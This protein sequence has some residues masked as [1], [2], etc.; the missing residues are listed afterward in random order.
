[1][2]W[3]DGSPLTAHDFEFA[4]KRNLDPTLAAPLASFLYPLTGAEDFFLGT[5]TDPSTVAVTAKDDV[6]LE[7]TLNAVTPYWLIIL[8]LWITMPIPKAAVDAGGATWA[9]PPTIVSNGWFTMESW[10]H[11]QS[12]TLVRNENFHGTKPLLSG[13]EYTIFQDPPTQGLTAFETEDVDLAQVTV[14]NADF[15]NSDPTLSELV[16][17]QAVSGTWQLRLDMSNTGIRDRATS[18]SARR[19]IWRSTAMC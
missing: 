15:V 14:A 4:I 13:I 1:M 7:M 17:H 11:D 2:V 8:S 12:M 5:T 6:T 3:S 18:T 16:Y 10:E 19:S 9:E